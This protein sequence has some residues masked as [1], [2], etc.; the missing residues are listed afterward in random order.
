MCVATPWGLIN[1]T[2]CASIWLCVIK[3]IESGR[4][5]KGEIDRLGWGGVGMRKQGRVDHISVFSALMERNILL[6]LLF[7]CRQQQRSV[8]GDETGSRPWHKRVRLDPKKSI[9][10]MF[11]SIKRTMS[12][13]FLH[14]IHY[15]TSTRPDTSVCWNKA[16]FADHNPPVIFLLSMD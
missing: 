6:Y 9:Q 16:Q 13:I 7:P 5:I 10:K 12:T 11:E 2:H 14:V 8:Q 1:T 15:E 3:Q 4:G